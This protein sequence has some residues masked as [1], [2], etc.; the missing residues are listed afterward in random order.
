MKKY[1]SFYRKIFSFLEVKLSIYLNRHVFVIKLKIRCRVLPCLH[2]LP[3]IQHFLKTVAS[4]TVL[5][6][7][8]S[9]ISHKK[10]NY[11]VRIY[12]V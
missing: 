4:P 12:F 2:R 1:Q 3:H 6:F 5:R 7:S 9:V 8:Q 10:P 11:S